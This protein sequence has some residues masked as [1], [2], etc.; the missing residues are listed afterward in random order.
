VEGKKMSEELKPCPFCGKPA[1]WEQAFLQKG[2]ARCSD[3]QCIG[4][5]TYLSRS[6]SVREW[7]TRPAEEV[8]KAE[9]ERLKKVLE[10]IQTIGFAETGIGDLVARNMMRKI[11]F[12][13]LAP[14]TGEKGGEDE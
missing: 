4:A 8:L 11:A 5:F 10:D 9:V 1:R 6:A 7:N 2:I 12:D 14:E 13:A 3:Y